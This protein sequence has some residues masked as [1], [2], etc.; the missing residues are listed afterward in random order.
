LKAREPGR[1]IGIITI[2][3]CDEVASKQLDPVPV[4]GEIQGNGAAGADDEVAHHPMFLIDV[5]RMGRGERS[6]VLCFA[7]DLFWALSDFIFRCS[8]GW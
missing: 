3:H 7:F 2:V 8:A 5:P 1:H 6:Q 4:V